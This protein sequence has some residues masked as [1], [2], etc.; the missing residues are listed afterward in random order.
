MWV[1]DKL[2]FCFLMLISDGVWLSV[3]V[4]T[5]RHVQ[6]HD[7][8][9][10]FHGR[11]QKSRPVSSGELELPIS[12]GT[13]ISSDINVIYW[14]CEGCTAPHRKLRAHYTKSTIWRLLETV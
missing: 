11:I 1:F 10:Y 7:S 13:Q 2:L 14:Q 4:Q 9:K 12:V 6:R 8:I 5:R 3:Y